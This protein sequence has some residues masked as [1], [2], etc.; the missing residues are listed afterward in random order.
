MKAEEKIKSTKED[1]KEEESPHMIRGE[2]TR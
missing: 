1:K 2:I